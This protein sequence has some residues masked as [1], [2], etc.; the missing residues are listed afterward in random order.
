MKKKLRGLPLNL[1]L[2]ADSTEPTD[3]NASNDQEEEVNNDET[4]VDEGEKKFSQEELNT[5]VEERLKRERE[6]ANKKQKEA[7]DKAVK[8]ALAK[9]KT[10]AKM[11]DAEKREQELKDR[12]VEIAA[13]E[14]EA[15]YKELL[16]DTKNVLADKQFPTELAELIVVKGDVEETNE[17]IN[18]FEEIIKQRDAERDKARLRQKDPRVGGQSSSSNLSEGARIAKERNEKQQKPVVSNWG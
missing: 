11:S 17:R 8:E 3:Q 15:D 13:R 12:E 18:R 2:F 14:A 4:N 7:I 9:E 10:L 5:V 16:S 6:T 1:Q